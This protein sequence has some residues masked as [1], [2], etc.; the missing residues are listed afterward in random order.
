M[1]EEIL[2]SAVVA[3]ERRQFRSERLRF[4]AE[5]ASVREAVTKR[6][7]E[8]AAG[9]DCAH[10]ALRQLG[11]PLT[12]LISSARGE[13]QWPPGVVGSITHTEGYCACAV[14][15]K[16]D[17][18]ALGIDAEPHVPLPQGVPIAS[19]ACANELPGLQRMHRES[20]EVH[21][22]RL[23]FSAK[24]SVFKAWYPLTKRELDFAKARVTFRAGGKFEASLLVAVPAIAGRSLNV[25]SGRWLVRDGLVLTV[26]LMPAVAYVAS[27]AEHHQPRG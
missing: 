7:R 12:P 19:I 8:F 2:P 4:A 15:R 27:E 21:V 14:A 17:I 3:T 22:D 10:E 16:G 6:R 26:A 9:R 13:P 1:I 18:V 24:E 23:L 20:P 5:R 11:C 25:W